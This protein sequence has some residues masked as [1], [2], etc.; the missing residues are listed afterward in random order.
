M[1]RILVELRM[2]LSVAV[3]VLPCL[4]VCECQFGG[5]QPYNGPVF[6][7]EFLDFEWPSSA[8]QPEDGQDGGDFADEGAGVFCEWTEPD[9]INASPDEI[10]EALELTC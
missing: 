7:V 2:A 6:V 10:K 9:V 5:H 4:R 1:N 3:D 8:V